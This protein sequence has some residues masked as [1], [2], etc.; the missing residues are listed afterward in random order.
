MRLENDALAV[1]NLRKLLKEIK[2][3][4]QIFADANAT[5]AQAFI[6]LQEKDS[7]V[8]KIK[9]A[10]KAIYAQLR[11]AWWK[12]KLMARFKAPTVA[13]AMNIHLNWGNRLEISNI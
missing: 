5:L 3:K 4:N 11:Q 6:N 7:A 9:I 10:I 2:F 8:A 13:K 1:N 12:N